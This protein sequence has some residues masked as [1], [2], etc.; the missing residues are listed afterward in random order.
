ME[1]TSCRL[2][3]NLIG[4]SEQVRLI[5]DP[6]DADIKQIID[7]THKQGGLVV[8]NHRPWSLN[9]LNKVPS[10]EDFYKYVSNTDPF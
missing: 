3:M 1:W 4:I 10:R 7:D 9:A 6:T 8:V 5:P 2:H